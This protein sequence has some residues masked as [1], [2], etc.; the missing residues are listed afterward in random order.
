MNT[1]YILSGVVPKSTCEMA[2]TGE[3]GD[4][5]F[6]NQ[7]ELPYI[8]LQH[9]LGSLWGWRPS[10]RAY[11]YNGPVGAGQYRPPLA[12]RFPHARRRWSRIGGQ[13]RQLLTA[14]NTFSSRQYV[15]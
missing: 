15:V 8:V 5:L 3:N 4:S 13:L 12:A 7:R 6:E 1:L 9:P 14:A 10:S 11:P 2:P